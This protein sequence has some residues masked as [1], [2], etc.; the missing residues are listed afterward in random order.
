MWGYCAMGFFSGRFPG[1]DAVQ[2]L[3]HSWKVQAQFHFHASG[4]IIFR[5]QN[6][7]DQ[8]QV[9]FPGQY[10]MFGC[11]MHI[12]MIPPYFNFDVAE[13]TIVPVWVTFP[14]LPLEYWSAK[15]LSRIASQ[16]GTPITTD[17][18]TKEKLC[19][20]CSSSSSH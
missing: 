18:L 12:R 14:N 15:P 2:K 19:C 17:Q 1:K 10:T 13:M 4:W 20:S 5:F 9:V 6:E 11:Q 7:H 16:V 8:D 3:C